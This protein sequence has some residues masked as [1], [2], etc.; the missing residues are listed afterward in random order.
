MAELQDTR[1]Q[2]LSVT[3]Q[4]QT[5]ADREVKS[6]AAT[7]AR[8]LTKLIVANSQMRTKIYQ[9]LSPTQQKKLDEIQRQ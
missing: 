7:Q 2:L 4:G 1:E 3:Q 9:L 6:L 5:K 8:N